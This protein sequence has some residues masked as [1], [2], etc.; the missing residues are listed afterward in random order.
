MN[1]PIPMAIVGTQPDHS[2]PE[3]D[4]NVASGS[5]TSDTNAASARPVSGTNVEFQ[6]NEVYESGIKNEDD[7][8]IMADNEAYGNYG[9]PNDDD[10]IIMEDNDAYSHN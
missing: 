3:S 6:D 5:P 10:E 8:V 4:T 7:E 9:Q 1:I 2:L